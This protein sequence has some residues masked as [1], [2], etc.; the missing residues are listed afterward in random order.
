MN[1]SVTRPSLDN[2]QI[3]NIAAC[4][5]VYGL[6][7]F[8][9]AISIY[10]KARRKVLYVIDDGL[11]I[12]AVI[13]LTG[14][15]AGYLYSIKLGF[16]KH[17]ATLSV[18]SIATIY[19]VFY[20]LEILY[21]FT[22]VAVKIS[23]SVM[24]YRIFHVDRSIKIIS[25]ILIVLTVCYLVVA[26]GVTIFQCIPVDK[27]W[28][29][30]PSSTSGSCMN[31]KA[32]Y[33][34]IAI[35]NIGTDFILTLLPIYCVVGL[36]MKTGAKLRICLMFSVGSIVTISSILRLWALLDLYYNPQDFTYIGPRPQ[37]WSFIETGMGIAISTGSPLIMQ[38][39]GRL[40]NF[41]KSSLGRRMNFTSN[42]TAR[43]ETKLRRP[44]AIILPVMAK[45]RK[46]D[47]YNTEN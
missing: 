38:L 32:I 26:L 9:T 34:G 47:Q 15:L 37:L 20:V 45:S 4:S 21:L 1:S 18:N 24:I 46:L 43:E 8:C 25:I 29:Y 11:M 12:L 10:N 5:V 14:E 44:E 27:A 42:R 30:P 33:L 17:M 28:S 7:I 3:A 31:L 2:A 16:G 6:A 19:K 39:G 22:V 13:S 23:L 36:C 41:Q 40:K 35:P